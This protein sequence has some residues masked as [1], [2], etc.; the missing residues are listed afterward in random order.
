MWAATL[1]LNGLLGAGVPWD[2]ATHM[3]GHELTA[4]HGIDHA[5]TLAVVL[6]SLLDVRFE[7]KRAKLAQFATRVLNIQEG[8]EA[9]RA[10]GAIE[11]I[12]AFFEALDV[13]TH[14]SAYQ[15]GAEVIPAVLTQL[16]AHGM[17]ALGERRDQTLEMSRAILQGAL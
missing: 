3:V 13:P 2:G 4:L 9:E 11:G 16:E 14:L 8:S 6:P 10:R 15:L 1:A 5:R 17:T 12:R 7:A